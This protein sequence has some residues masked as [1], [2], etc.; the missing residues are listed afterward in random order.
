MT[1]FT[2]APQPSFQ[3]CAGLALTT[4]DS[5][6]A[7]LGCAPIAVLYEISSKVDGIAIGLKACFV[8]KA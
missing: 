4:G 6:N 8:K 3:L 7:L 1:L 5:S 2:A